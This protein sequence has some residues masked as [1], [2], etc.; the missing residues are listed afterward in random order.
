MCQSNSMKDIDDQLVSVCAESPEI[1]AKAEL[2]FKCISL[3]HD[4]IPMVIDGKK[5]LSGSS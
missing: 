2:L 4:I 3:C 1:L 5:V